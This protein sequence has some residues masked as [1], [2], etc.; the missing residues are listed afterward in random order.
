MR[1]LSVFNSISLDGYF[2]DQNNDMS[3]ANQSDPEF[4]KFTTD[5]TKGGGGLMLFGR[6]TYELM[7]SFWPTP[8]AE[9]LFPEVAKTMNEASKIVFSRTLETADW[10]N[11]RL[12]NDNLVEEVRRLKTEDGDDMLIMGSGTIVSQLT[13]AKLIDDFQF[14]VVPIVLGRGRTLFEGVTEKVK[15]KRTKERAFQN[16]N[17]FVCYEVS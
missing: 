6:V 2:T 8:Q 15:L 17:V 10:N 7:K 12:V 11:T 4:D 13:Q 16:G 9:Q 5:N 1:K 14:I 3:W